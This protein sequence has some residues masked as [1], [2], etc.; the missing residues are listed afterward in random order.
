[1][2]ADTRAS[3][4]QV[5]VRDA[6]GSTTPWRGSPAPGHGQSCCA[7]A[8]LCFEEGWWWRVVY[9]RELLR[10]RFLG[11]VQY[12]VEY[13]VDGNTVVAKALSKLRAHQNKT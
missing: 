4:G 12:G 10:V 13:G 9:S 2:V 5:P 3:P 6:T 7:T 1:M 8:G 11:D